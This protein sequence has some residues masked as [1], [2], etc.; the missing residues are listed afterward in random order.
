[1]NV[2]ALQLYEKGV[3][4]MAGMIREVINVDK[5]QVPGKV[6]GRSMGKWPHS[7][8]HNRENSTAVLSDKGCQREAMLTS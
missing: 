2:T 6:G 7:R 5:W 3:E 8:V 1:M 4:N